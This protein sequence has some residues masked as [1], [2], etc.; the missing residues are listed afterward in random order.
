MIKNM[1]KM[2]K[3]RLI[4]DLILLAILIGIGV[5]LS[6]VIRMP[7]SSYSGASVPPDTAE[8]QTEAFL[9]K[10]IQVLAGDIGQRNTEE[11]LKK[12]VDY[13]K[14]S[15]ASYGYETQEQEFEVDKQ[16]FKNLECTLKGKTND[17]IILGAHYDSV[18]GS[19]GAD[20]N[21]S[22]VATVMELARLSAKKQFRKTVRFV[23]FCNEEPPYFASKEMGSYFYA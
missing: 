22:G 20:D 10:H 18:T 23:F 16:K 8:N 11:S 9:R 19:T 7:G 13:I 17:I 3:A 15:M 6:S 1:F 12:S 14:S 2:T 21:G 5:T 4:V